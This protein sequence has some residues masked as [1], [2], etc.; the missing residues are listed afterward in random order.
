[1]NWK[2]TL[3][4]LVLAGVAGVLA[5]QGLHLPPGLDPARAP[6]PAADLGTR[7]ELARLD[8]SRLTR[9]VVRKGDR[10]TRLERKS[11]AEWTMPGNWPV[12]AAEAE[13]LA[14]LLGGLRSRF[15]AEPVQGDAA[16]ASRGLRPPALVVE[17]ATPDHT[18]HMA[19]GE[20][21]GLPGSAPFSHA[22]YLRLGDREEV[23][24]LAPGLVARLDRPPD[25]YQ[26]RR[27]F[28]A[29]RVVKDAESA[30]KA[31]RLAGRAVTFEDHPRGDGTK[32]TGPVSLVRKGD[33]WELEWLPP[34]HKKPLRDRPDA[35]ARDALLAAVPD[36]WAEDFVTHDPGAVAALAAAGLCPHLPAAVTAAFWATPRGLIVKSG[37]DTPQREIAVTRDDG[38]V[39]T[40]QVGRTSGS[41][42]R[43]VLRP[44]PPGMPPGMQAREETVFDEY[45]YARLQGNDE[46]FEVRGDRLKDVFVP[47]DAL[48]DSR[49][50][51]FETADARRVEVV[52]GSHR[53]VLEKDKER[54]KLVEPVRAEADAGKVTDL[55]SK[56]SALQARD[57]DLIDDGA[58]GAY[59]LDRPSAVVTVTYEEQT[60]DARG[61]KVKKERA[62]RVKVGRHDAA[63]KK[64]YLAVDD[65]PRVNAVEDDL[66]SLVR[67]P[68]VAYRGKHVFDFAG[69][70]VAKVEVRRGGEDYV[71][72]RG[73][74]GWRLVKPVTAQA[75]AVKAD[76]LVS[77]LAGA[78]ALEFA[79]EGLRPADVEVKYGLARPAVVVH[80]EFT[81]KTKPART[82][83]VG[84]HRPGGQP[85]RYARL[86]EAAAQ[87]PVFVLPDDVASALDRDSLAYRPAQLWQ[88]PPD[89]VASVRVRR[90]GEPEY[91]VRREGEAWRVSGPFEAPARADAAAALASELA[92]PQATAY[93]AHEAKDL[94]P[95]GLDRP[96]LSVAVAEKDGKEHT[97]LLGKPAGKDGRYARLAS[98]TAVFVVGDALAR[99]ADRPALEMLDP[100]L[101]RLH[102]DDIRRVEAKL[103]EGSLVIEHDTRGWH[104]TQGPGAPFE[105]DADAMAGLAGVCA[106]LKAEPFAAYGPGV[107][108]AKYGLDKAATRLVVFTE[109]QGGKPASHTIELGSSVPGKPGARYARVDREP[110]AAVLSP[111]AVSAL[112][113][114]PLG[115]VNR[116]LLS[117]DPAAAQSLR[118][119]AGGETLEVVHKDGGWHIIK[120]ADERADDRSLQE[121][122]HKLGDLHARRIAAY[123][124]GALNDYGLDRP[125]AVL[126]V[127]LANGK[128]AEHVVR[129]GKSAGGKD[130]YAQV[131]DGRAVAV[132]DGR[133]AESLLAPPLAFRDHTLA[134]FA[135]ADH[136]RLDRGRRKAVFARVDGTWKLTEPFAGEAEHDELEDFVGTLARL[137]ADALVDDRPT[138]EALR[139]YGLDHPEA[140]WRLSA[141]D[142]A[143]LDLEVGNVEDGGDRR[144]ARLGGAGTVFLLDS[145]LSA[146][147]VGEFRPRAV[148]DPPLD[149]AQV[150]S[151]HFGNPRGPFTLE[152]ADGGWQV[153]GKPELKVNAETVNDA[154]AAL[155]NLKVV[156]YVVDQGADPKLFG[157]D[158]PRLVLEVATRSGKRTLEV[159]AQEGGTRAHYARVAGGSRG[160]V[161]VLGGA[162]CAGLL[163]DAAAF[164]Q[165]PAASAPGPSGK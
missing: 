51:P 149:A 135:D 121:L 96:P 120:P 2:T 125:E 141:G 98:G 164:T 64:L 93:K 22:T 9:I 5:W 44:P 148:W 18:W 27:L 115:Y 24:R 91:S 33:A 76:G 53:I 106:E 47:L 15:E 10:V 43:R 143:V 156:R 138:A 146:R 40:L 147:A 41:R 163:R 29:E 134:R 55:V 127:R 130:R 152:R 144:Y 105:A 153:A 129:L 110:G 140:H 8:A 62:V 112:A 13:G 59:G 92:A 50:V 31:E 11:G 102:A 154:L 128:P 61:E 165:P 87:A 7:A 111:S 26:Q 162:D 122:L 17:A 83:E 160:G 23:V 1:M 101:V 97:L 90:E 94:A 67:R 4:L 34:G 161:F 6:A 49:V 145:R 109:P 85:G 63:A 32:A 103:P 123:P 86:A 77:S 150:E 65:W 95:Y 119:Q 3:A 78:E 14:G 71:L 137:R 28:G 35:R 88:L 46:V 16:L 56:L 142:K 80:L 39:V 74:D 104:V 133:L 132:L 48:R 25:Y 66:E 117:F 20:E 37:L 131:D 82:L 89:D 38:S 107:D 69:A 124:A 108:W 157:L 155:A 81:D 84:K 30:E 45:R 72:E 42:A 21:V 136:V 36:V 113:R 52:Q 58:P 68:A 139:K 54:W 99:A 60:K 158:S 100:V 79:D 126:T 159:G 75:D 12:R 116:N 151:L 114:P 57:K 19:L 70:D 118:R 73:K